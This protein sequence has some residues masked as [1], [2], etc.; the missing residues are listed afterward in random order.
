MCYS[1]DSYVIEEQKKK[2][3]WLFVWRFNNRAT[4]SWAHGLT[5]VYWSVTIARFALFGQ[6]NK[7]LNSNQIKSKKKTKKN[8]YFIIWKNL[9]NEIVQVI[10]IINTVC[11]CKQNAW[12]KERWLSSLHIICARLIV[13]T[14]ANAVSKMWNPIE[15]SSL[16]YIILSVVMTLLKIAQSWK[17]PQRNESKIKSTVK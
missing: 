7:N 13:H 11:V 8:M 2:K 4:G 14:P 10:N 3:S 17:K 1:Q 9:L 12:Q 15:L 5:K 6:Y 16:S